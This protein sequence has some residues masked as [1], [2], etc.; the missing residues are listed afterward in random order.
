M[1][2][3][4]GK[5]KRADFGIGAFLVG[6]VDQENQVKTIAKIGTGLTDAEFKQ[7]KLLADDQAVVKKPEQYDVPKT[8]VPDVWVAPSLVVE[9]VADEL[10]TSPLHTAK[11]ALRFPRLLKI[12]T[13]KS[14]E[15]ATKLL[16]LAEIRIA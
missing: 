2:Y 15:Q 13:D 16:E 9:I 4:R 3:Y 12:R 10:T 14:W 11:Q 1:G 7:I 5:G 8:L 6:V